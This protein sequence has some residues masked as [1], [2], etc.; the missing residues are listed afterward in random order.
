MWP[1]PRRRNLM[2]EGGNFGNSTPNGFA[3]ARQEMV[4][5]QIRKRHI[6]DG[7]VLEGLQR[8][9]RPEFVPAEFRERAYEDAPLPI[10]D[11]ETVSHPSILSPIPPPPHLQVAEHTS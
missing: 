7:R 5:T 3:G 2:N 1:L 11:G 4:E 6:T 9:P 8:V 10:G